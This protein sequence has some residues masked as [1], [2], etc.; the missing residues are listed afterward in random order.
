LVCAAED[1]KTTKSEYDSYTLVS[2]FLYTVH[3]A[4]PVHSQ[5]AFGAAGQMQCVFMQMIYRERPA[6]MYT[7]IQKAG[8]YLFL[9]GKP[10]VKSKHGAFCEVADR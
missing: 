4:H 6:N 10:A 5:T 2:L 9:H 3:V 8:I 1:P 7:I